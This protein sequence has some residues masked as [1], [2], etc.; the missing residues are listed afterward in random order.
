M[1]GE[2]TFSSLALEEGGTEY[3]SVSLED[4][5]SL[6]CLVATICPA[7]S[8]RPYFIHLARCGVIYLA[9]YH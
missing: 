2:V 5:V 3:R 6:G 9:L 4:C 8:R 1:R 7:G